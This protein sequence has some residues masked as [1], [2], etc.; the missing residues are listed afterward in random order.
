MAAAESVVSDLRAER[1]L[2]T[3]PHGHILTNANGWSPDGEWIV[4]DVRSDPA[5]SVFDGTRIEAVHVESGEVRVLYESQNGAC[6]GAAS[7]CPTSDK[8]VFIHGPENPT[9]DWQYNA[10]HRRG[11]V[12]DF[13]VAVDRAANHGSAAAETLDARDLMPPFTPGAL[14]GGTHLH[15][16]SP[17]GQWI[18]FTYED[19]LLANL[20]LGTSADSNQRNIGVAVPSE[21]PVRV[22]RDHPR[23]HD[24]THF[25]IVVTQTVNQPRPGSDEI[26]RAC[27]EA[28]IGTNGYLRSDG[29]RQR[30]AL[31]FQGTVLTERSLAIAE[32]FIVDLPDDLTQPGNGPL[33]G[34]ATRRP[35][36]PRGVVQRR[37]TYTSDRRHPGLQGPR[38]WLRSAPDGSR[39]AM[40][41]KD[42]AGVV[43]L[44]TISPNGGEPRQLTHNA[45]DIASAFTWSPDGGS[46]AHVLAGSVC[47]TDAEAG[48]TRRITPRQP[49]EFA[50][51]PEACV[52]STQGD[53]I[54][55]VRPAISGGRVYNQIFIVP[56]F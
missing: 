44:W 22:K 33:A 20:P 55:Y 41:M 48:L 4:Y 18:A 35:F 13:R 15:I 19:H 38:H 3:A 11:V 14:R 21:R 25:S 52:Y 47:I 16:Y 50:P 36:P 26:S 1:Q 54:A 32:A 30:R 7:F 53:K 56:L 45:Y 39:I 43:Q 29:T 23:N 24:G 28:W 12:V 34:T 40:L 37:L 8:V 9:P 49:A 51:R 2:T 31:A 6:C 17:D 10:W 42:D 46:I 27:E 5:G